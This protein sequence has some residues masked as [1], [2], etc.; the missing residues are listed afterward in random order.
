[1]YLNLMSSLDR[2]RVLAL[3][4]VH[5]D[6]PSM[7][8]VMASMLECFDNVAQLSRTGHIDAHCYCTNLWI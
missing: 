5:Q 4:T 8:F 6:I 2:M 1:M 3:L 7:K